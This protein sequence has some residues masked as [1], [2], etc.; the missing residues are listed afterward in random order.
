[1]SKVRLSVE[2]TGVERVAM[3]GGVAANSALREAVASQDAW[4][5]YLP[6]RELC[7]DNAVMIAAAGYDAYVRGLRSDISF[8]PDPSL[9]LAK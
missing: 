9:V 4:E 5:A 6:P 8:S 3:S 2:M 7:T 1:M